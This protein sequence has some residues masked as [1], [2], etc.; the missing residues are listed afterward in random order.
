MSVDIYGL[1]LQPGHCEVHPVV[2]VPFPCPL[3]MVER[4]GERLVL[5]PEP[6]MWSGEENPRIQEYDGELD[7]F[8]ASDVQAVHFEATDQSQWYA[9]VTMR[10]GPVWQLTFGAKNVNAK[11]FAHVEQI[12]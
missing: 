11:G 2:G 5:H 9:T 8:L 10:D 6:E 7:D 1:P 4:A 12:E 3:C